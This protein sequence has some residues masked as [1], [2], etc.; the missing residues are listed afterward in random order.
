MVNLPV[1][2]DVSGRNFRRNTCGEKFKAVKKLSAVTESLLPF[3]NGPPRLML[4][5]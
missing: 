4:G 5:N 3:I 1:H 2:P